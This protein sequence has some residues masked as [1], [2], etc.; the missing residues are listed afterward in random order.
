M[1]S[2]AAVLLL[3]GSIF[4]VSYFANSRACQFKAEAMR[5]SWSYSVLQDCMIV[6]D[7]HMVPL[8]AYRM[9]KVLP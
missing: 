6:V 9:I 8:T 3:V 5:V 2:A 1:A 7:G 4:G